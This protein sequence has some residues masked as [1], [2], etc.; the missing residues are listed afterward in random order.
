M[1]FD[2]Y[3]TASCAIADLAEDVW[4]KREFFLKDRDYFL[5]SYRVSIAD[6]DADKNVNFF[7]HVVYA[8]DRV[9]YT[10]SDEH[11]FSVDHKTL[12]FREQPEDGDYFIRAQS[13][14]RYVFC[15]LFQPA[16]LNKMEKVAATLK[17]P[18]QSS[19]L[20]DTLPIEEFRVK[21]KA[22]V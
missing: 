1:H 21:Q 22:E 13:Y 10:I 15:D 20:W 6:H 7:F 8:R 14:R 12:I 3:F 5:V 9:W 18:Q 4:N 16:V 19:F 17:N 2:T 11:S